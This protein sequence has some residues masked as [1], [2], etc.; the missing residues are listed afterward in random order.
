[1]RPEHV[2]KSIPLAALFLVLA[3]GPSESSDARELE[4]WQLGPDQWPTTCDE[5][6]N[7]ALAYLSWWGRWKLSQ[8]DESELIQTH[9]GLGLTLRNRQGLWRGNDQLIQSCLGHPGHP[10]SASAEI[11]RRAW[12]KARG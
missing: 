11:V 2:P 6:A 8:L 10:D 3:C 9:F 5:A 7:D 1:M 12:M 4:S